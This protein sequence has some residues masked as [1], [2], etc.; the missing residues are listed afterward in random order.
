MELFLLLIPAVFLP[1]G[2]SIV[3]I[4][5]LLSEDDTDSDEVIDDEGFDGGM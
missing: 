1:I 3:S 2:L 5:W 4:W